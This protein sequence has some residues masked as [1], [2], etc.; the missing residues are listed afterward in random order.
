[1]EIVEGTT[2]LFN[3][4]EFDKSN[5]FSKYFNDTNIL[6]NYLEPYDKIYNFLKNEIVPKYSNQIDSCIIND[7]SEEIYIDVEY[8]FKIKPEISSEELN[9]LSLNI[10]AELF[11]ECDKEDMLSYYDKTLII[12]SR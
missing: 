2:K 1:M 9:L 12:L 4:T 3:A 5:D 11:F 6:K 7:N 8:I 10:N